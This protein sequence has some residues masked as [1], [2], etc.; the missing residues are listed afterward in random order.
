MD[1]DA[2]ERKLRLAL[3]VCRAVLITAE[4]L[5]AAGRGGV[6]HNTQLLQQYCVLRYA[7]TK[8]Q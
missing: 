1:E 7:H 3:P 6:L 8:I 2:G 4:S 5:A